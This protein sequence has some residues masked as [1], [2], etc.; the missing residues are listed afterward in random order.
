MR[1]Q[2]PPTP[3]CIVPG[4]RDNARS[5]AGMKAHF[6]AKGHVA[7]NL[8]SGSVWQVQNA[9][10]GGPVGVEKR[11]VDCLAKLGGFAGD[12]VDTLVLLHPDVAI[13]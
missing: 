1:R 2:S 5:D 11:A 10:P 3:E 4:K 6:Q 9:W 13:N 7:R 8:D 12:P